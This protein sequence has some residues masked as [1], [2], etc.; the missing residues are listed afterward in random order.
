MGFKLFS[1]Q[2]SHPILSLD[3]AH[4]YHKDPSTYLVNTQHSSEDYVDMFTL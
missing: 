3:V 1:R 4:L 2:L